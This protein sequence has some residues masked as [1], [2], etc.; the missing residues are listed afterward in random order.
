M[1]HAGKQREVS[2]YDVWVDKVLVHRMRHS[3][4]K[5]TPYFQWRGQRWWRGKNFKA[6]EK[7]EPEKGDILNGT[8]ILTPSQRENWFCE[9]W[10]V[11][12]S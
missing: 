7:E 2:K 9:S 5:V 10:Y 1:Y 4:R 12:K 6:N 3:R 8:E 11:A